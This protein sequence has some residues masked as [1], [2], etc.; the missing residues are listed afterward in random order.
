MK[1]TCEACSE[2]FEI[3]DTRGVTHV[4]CPFCDHSCDIR[5]DTVVA[6]SRA[7]S[8]A[9]PPS[10]GAHPLSRTRHPLAPQLWILA[11]CALVITTL[12]VAGTVLTLV[13]MVQVQEEL[14]RLD[15]QMEKNLIEPLRQSFK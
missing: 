15:K 9:S 3:A 12:I 2:P 11:I 14:E 5:K 1:L 13:A 6:R 4:V 8:P 10:M 7:P